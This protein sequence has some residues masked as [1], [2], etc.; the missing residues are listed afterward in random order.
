MKNPHL[1]TT[2]IPKEGGSSQSVHPWTGSPLVIHVGTTSSS[3]PL[4]LEASSNPIPFHIPTSM[5]SLV[6]SGLKEKFS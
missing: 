2:S 3:Q 6:Q 1:S 5:S 4:D